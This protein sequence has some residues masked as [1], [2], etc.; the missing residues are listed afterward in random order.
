MTPTNDQD[1]TDEQ[2]QTMCIAIA[3]KLGLDP[4][5]KCDQHSE[6]TGPECPWCNW[7]A[8]LTSGVTFQPIPDF[9]GDAN[10]ALLLVEHMRKE[11]WEFRC[12]TEQTHREFLVQFS[13]D[14]FAWDAGEL[15]FPIAV[16]L[17]FAKAN[18]LPI[19]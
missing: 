15:T 12:A 7:N 8:T 6:V 19:P 10:D 11:G 2:K 16:S 4:Y 9:L 14:E 1:M 17:A 3:D 13:N 5:W 18:Q